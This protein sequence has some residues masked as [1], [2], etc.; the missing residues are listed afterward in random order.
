MHCT[1]LVSALLCA[2]APAAMQPVPGMDGGQIDAPAVVV[3]APAAGREE[4]G[5]DE[6]PGLEPDSPRLAIGPIEDDGYYTGDH[7]GVVGLPALD[8]N[9]R[10]VV[11]LVDH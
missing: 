2:C 7:V 1:L 10:V 3:A 11:A 8:R 5:I 4:P 6:E 9:G